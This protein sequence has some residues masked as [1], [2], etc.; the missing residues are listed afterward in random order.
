MKKTIMPTEQHECV[1]LRVEDCANILGVS[2]SS[3]YALVERAF[4]DH[5]PFKVLKIGK[6]YRILK[7]SFYDFVQCKTESSN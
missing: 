2:L 5:A 6:C 7:E 3:A 1:M 4:K